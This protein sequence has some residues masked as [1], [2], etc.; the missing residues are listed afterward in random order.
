[1]VE[2]VEEKVREKVAKKA[3]N[4]SA[5]KKNRARGKKISSANV[6]NVSRLT[7]SLQDVS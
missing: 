1:M 6:I 7:N 5:R 4:S 3:R 2:K